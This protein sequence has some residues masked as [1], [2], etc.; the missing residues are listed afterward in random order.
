MPI[1]VNS[2]L[3]AFEC[4]GMDFIVGLPPSKGFDAIMV[5]VDKFTKTGIFIPTTSGY[6]AVSAAELFVSSAVA[7]AGRR[8]L[9]TGCG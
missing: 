2:D 8:E 3:Y 4:V 5:I 6:T 1:D 7:S 9:G